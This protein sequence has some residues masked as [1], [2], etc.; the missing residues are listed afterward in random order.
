[1]GVVLF[2]HPSEKWSFGGLYLNVF[3]HEH[4]ASETNFKMAHKLV[5]Y[6]NF[7]ILFVLNSYKLKCGPVILRHSIYSMAHFVG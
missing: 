1:M 2:P 7:Y 3:Q 5:R 6:I 4:F